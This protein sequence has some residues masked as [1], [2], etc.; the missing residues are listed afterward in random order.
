M[1]EYFLTLP[2]FGCYLL[3]SCVDSYLFVICLCSDPLPRAVYLAYKARK[4][5][6]VLSDTSRGRLTLRQCDR[7]GRLL[8]ESLKLIYPEEER[9]TVKVGRCVCL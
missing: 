8:R 7:A 3:H 2:A 6:M 5:V 1:V 9:T 4:A